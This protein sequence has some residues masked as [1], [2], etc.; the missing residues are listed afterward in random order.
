MLRT[1]NK[2]VADYSEWLVLRCLR[3]T[4]ACNTSSSHDTT[5]V[6]G[7][8]YQIKGRRVGPKIKSVQLSDIRNLE[9][10]PFEVLV[11]LIFEFDFSIQHAAAV[12]NDMVLEYA[13]YPKHTNL[14]LFH[15]L[16]SLFK[17]TMIYDI[18]PLMSIIQ[19]EKTIIY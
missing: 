5:D 18:R 19:A 12:S 6:K 2:P 13:S 3:L 1:S 8:K 17:G 15:V 16:D 11:T 14:H 10:R 7:I 9:T 4:L